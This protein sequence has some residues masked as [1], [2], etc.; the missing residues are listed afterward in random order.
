[1]PNTEYIQIITRSRRKNKI[2]NSNIE[3]QDTNILT[4]RKRN[5]YNK[6]ETELEDIA[7]RVLFSLKYI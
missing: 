7:I 4:K 1:M 2:S 5:S 3:T 6:I